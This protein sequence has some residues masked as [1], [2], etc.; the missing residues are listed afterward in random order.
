[1]K[2]D[3]TAISVAFGKV[4]CQLREKK[5]QTQA[6]LA[7]GSKLDRTFISF[8]ERGMRQPTLATLVKIAKALEIRPSRIVAKFEENLP[9]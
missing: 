9:G 5:G 4:L 8:L 3:P 6:E 1:M 7:K 2:I